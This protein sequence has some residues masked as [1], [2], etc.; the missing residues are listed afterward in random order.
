MYFSSLISYTYY[1]LNPYNFP[2]YCQPN[3]IRSTTYFIKLH[4]TQT[5]SAFCYFPLLKSKLSSAHSSQA[6]TVC[7]SCRLLGCDEVQFG[8]SVPT[9]QRHC[10]QTHRPWWQRYQIPLNV[11]ALVPGYIPDDGHLL[12]HRREN[13]SSSF[14]VLSWEGKLLLHVWSRQSYSPAQPHVFR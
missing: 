7:N 14:C 6:L 5:S 13:V 9:F 11:D 3:S 2:L 4:S 8:R 12:N 1:I 10:R